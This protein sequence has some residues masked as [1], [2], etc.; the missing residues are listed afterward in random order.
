MINFSKNQLY[1]VIFIITLFISSDAFS[2]N[3]M[4]SDDESG[5]KKDRIPQPVL[6]LPD[7]AG[8]L[9][10]SLA[11]IIKA[12]GIKDE[13]VT[14]PAV[15]EP[16][17][18]LF[19]LGKQ[20]FFS[21]SMS[22]QLDVACASCHHPDLAGGDAL[23]L[24]VGVD[25]VNPDLLGPGRVHDGDR[26]KDP[27]TDGGPNVPRNAPTIF[28]LHI[29]DRV[30]FWDGR[31]EVVGASGAAHG[32]GLSI[33]TPDSLRKM[34]DPSAGTNLTVAQARFPITS[35]NEMFGHGAGAMTNEDKRRLL[36]KRFQGSDSATHKL[37][38]NHW[39]PLFQAAFD[40]ERQ[41]PIQVVTMDRIS[42]ALSHYQRSLFFVDNPWSKYLSGDES[43]ISEEA[44]KGALL[45]YSSLEQGGYACNACHTGNRFTDEGFY[46][47][48]MPQFGRGKDRA[49]FDLGRM[50]ESSDPNDR[51]AFRTPTL[52]NVAETGPWGHTGA[53]RSLKDV[54]R[55]HMDT[56]TSLVAFDYSLQNNPQFKGIKTDREKFFNRSLETLADLK[57][58]EE[59]QLLPKWKYNERDADLIEAF[60]RTLTDPC[61][62]EKRCLAN[63]IPKQGD[64]GPDGQLLHAVFSTFDDQ[65]ITYQPPL[66]QKSLQSAGGPASGKTWFTD[67]TAEAGLDYHLADAGNGDEQHRVSGGVAVDD[68]DNDGWPDLFFSHSVVPGKLFRNQ[69]DGTFR[70]TTNEAL[71]HLLS[72]QFGA[73]FFDYDNDQDK[74]LLLVE[75][76]I[77]DNFFRVYENQGDGHMLPDPLKGGIRFSRFTHSLSAGDYDGDGDLD[78]YAA[79]W[80]FTLLDIYNEYLWRNE[81]NG[82]FTDNSKILPP[83]RVSPKTDTLQL[84]FTPIFADIDGD[85]DP[86]MLLAGDFT[87]SQILI[88]DGGNAFIDKTTPVISD[89]NGM[90]AAVGDF[91]NDGDLD[92]FVTSIWNPIE[93]KAY[94]G[95]E[96][97]NRL[98]RNDGTGNFTDVTDEADV[99][100]GYWGWGACFADFNNDGWL[101]IFHTNGMTSKNVANE[102]TFAQFIHDPSRL[103]IN[104]HDGTFTERGVELGL[105][106]TDQGRGVSCF[107]Y[108]RDGDLD[109]LIGHSGAPPRL[110]KN[111]N[112]DGNNFLSITL[113][114]PGNNPEAVG[115]KIYATT[116][117]LT[118]YRELR[119]GSNYLSNDPILAH[120]GLG[121][122]K[123]VD[124]LRIVWPDGSEQVKKR[125]KANQHL[126]IE[127]TTSQMAQIRQ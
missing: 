27:L 61:I 101:D 24:S 117:K 42:E 45:F 43:A 72:Q 95:G 44:K 126:V 23:S 113:R 54:I 8:E 83:T 25:A 121:H 99:R 3:L 114:Q 16:R 10:R 125:V 19:E 81:G 73:L 105:N 48:A 104:N 71:G 77:H 15:T 107:D 69:H 51:Y 64:Q 119:M 96:T 36:E 115:A 6:A 41:D 94:I 85:N 84:N 65:P 12:L 75:D 89:E 60:L 87:T 86:D 49:G 97:G 79:H 127:K 57:Q 93:T 68:Y 80:G 37:P 103:Y 7:N 102:A 38:F 33:R 67:A 63:W 21:K 118:Q 78:L 66:E 35:G 122:K 46:N 58:S 39:L 108:D 90:G 20:L 106:H 29:Y 52:L 28:N 82:T 124:R 109:I 40:D 111:N 18:P 59:W 116:G 62:T 70:E 26:S 1:L 31:V 110:Y 4:E 34:P 11:Q 74:D 98:Y 13:P 30:Q 9:D 32:M 88:N 47:I 120:F 123:R 92:W 14:S 5:G 17:G 50:L 53:F 91:D 56:E 55:H 76:N 22:E 2:K 100:K 112:A